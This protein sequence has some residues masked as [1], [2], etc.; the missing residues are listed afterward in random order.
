MLKEVKEAI[1][2]ELKETMRV[3]LGLENINKEVEIIKAK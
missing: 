1:Y 2:K 3:C